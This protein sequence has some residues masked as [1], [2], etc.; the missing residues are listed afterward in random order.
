[1]VDAPN[2]GGTYTVQDTATAIQ[3]EVTDTTAGSLD[4]ATSVATTDSDGVSPP[5]TR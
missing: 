2:T 1:M 3:A 4:G 5:W